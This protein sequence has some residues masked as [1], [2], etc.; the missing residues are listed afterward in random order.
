MSQNKSFPIRITITSERYEIAASLFSEV[1]G[2]LSQMSEALIPVS[3]T[4][5]LLLGI[6]SDTLEDDEDADSLERGGMVSPYF[7]K[8]A[9]PSVTESR[10]TGQET[11]AIERMEIITEGKMTVTRDP[12][13]ETVSLSYA[14]TEAS[15]M[16]GTTTAITF[17]RDDP[18]LVTMVRSGMVKTAMTFRA[19]HRAVCAYNTPYMPFEVCVHALTVDNRVGTLLG[20]SILLDYLMEIKGGVAERCTMR[21]KV[22]PSFGA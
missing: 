18:G 14:E 5:E 11:D 13:G 2:D 12:A 16:P 8:P 9:D 19:H 10:K 3:S 20:G 15:G 21:I 1:Y 17:R 4:E 22:T 7:V 6:F